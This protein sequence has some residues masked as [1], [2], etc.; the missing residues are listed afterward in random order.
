MIP[1]TLL[2][3]FAAR[4]PGK[5]PKSPTP[6]TSEVSVPL[7]VA[8]AIPTGKPRRSREPASKYPTPSHWLE[9]RVK[10]YRY[11]HAL[12]VVGERV[13]D[14]LQSFKLDYEQLLVWFF[15]L[16]IPIF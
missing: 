16:L 7:H 2:P 11:R 14:N 9:S 8:S 4:S 1:L 6:A 15:P 13:A 10:K 12:R 3:R 5:S